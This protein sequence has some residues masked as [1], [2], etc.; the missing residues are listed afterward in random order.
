MAFRNFVP[1]ARRPRCY[2]DTETTGVLAGWNEITELAFKHD[3]MG[4]WSVR[5]RPKF[6]DRAHPR[7]LEISGY[8]ER[9]WADAPPIEDM[10]SRICAFLKDVIIVGHN[11]AGF[12]LPILE[13]ESRMKKLP[14]GDISRAWEDTQG[15]AQT[16]LVPRGLKRV[17]LK[18]CCDYFD[19]GNQGEHHAL[20]DVLR[21]EKVYKKITQGQQGL[22]DVRG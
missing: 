19:I 21:T 2:F 18:A 12:D 20:E 9:D 22:F 5:V 14:R 8:N 17:S 16:L 7:A 4:T 13:G 3:T 10:W 11:V 1:Y 15:L 6:M